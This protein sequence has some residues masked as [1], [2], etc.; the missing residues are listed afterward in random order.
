MSRTLTY[1]TLALVLGTTSALAQRSL[2][3]TDS[4][5]NVNVSAGLSQNGTGVYYQHGYNGAPGG[6]APS[7]SLSVTGSAITGSN[8]TSASFA[9]TDRIA[10]IFQQT[11]GGAGNPGESGHPGQ[12]GGASG[13]ITTTLTNS[14]LRLDYLNSTAMPYIHG[15]FAGSLGASGGPSEHNDHAGGDGSAAA[16]VNLVLNGSNVTATSQ[17]TTTQ[18]AAVTALQQGGFGG[19]GQHHGKG[20]EGGGSAPMSVTLQDST[21]SAQGGQ[22]AGVQLL[23]TGGSGGDGADE[24]E[25]NG[26]TG[27]ILQGITL[28][29]QQSNGGAGNAISTTGNDAPAIQAIAIGGQGG[30]GGDDNFVGATGGDGGNGGNTAHSAQDMA[31]RLTGTGQLSITTQG[32]SS[33]GIEVLSQ[34]GDG[35]EGGLAG[36]LFAGDPGQAGTGGRGDQIEIHLGAGATITTHGDTSSAILARTQGGAGATSGRDNGDASGSTTHP[37]GAGGNSGIVTV[38]LDQGVTLTTSGTGSDGITALSVSGRGG[39]AGSAVGGFG[40]ATAGN[41]GNGGVAGG[42]NINSAGSITTTG[43]SARGIL[44]QT[45]SGPGGNGGRASAV[46]SSESGGPGSAGVVNGS[47]VVQSGVITTGGSYSQGILVQ[48]IAGTG[49]VGGRADSSIFHDQ[50]GKAAPGS[51]GGTIDLTNTGTI[52]TAGESAQ[53]IVAQSIGGGGG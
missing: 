36:Y 50:G 35:G 40:T 7:I 12:N 52:I 47:T 41:G 5:N 15:L 10:A 22:L 1:S 26:G 29:L 37:G 32:T 20:G 21:I 23:Q 4:L 33:A 48:S 34:G 51:N 8:V 31:I 49:G 30:K 38:T 14:S 25:S 39:D 9:A 46:L 16:Q 28:T 42:V 13:P 27:G 45:V 44:A 6:A 19:T 18:G 43:A 3:T 2:S 24:Q 53:A 11:N 17:N